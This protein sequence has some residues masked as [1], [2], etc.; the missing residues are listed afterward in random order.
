MTS[1]KEDK[2]ITS[3]ETSSLIG[4]DSPTS[5]KVKIKFLY[6]NPNINAKEGR[7]EIKETS[8]EALIR[9]EE[10]LSVYL[11]YNE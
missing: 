10:G 11:R 2:N 8:E 3:K 5:S 1:N 6:F 7:T 4:K 9:E